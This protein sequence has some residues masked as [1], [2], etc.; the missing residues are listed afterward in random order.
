MT[1]LPIWFEHYN[2]VQ[3]HKALGYRSP[4]EPKVSASKFIAERKPK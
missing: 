1:M 4:R 2:T 3:P